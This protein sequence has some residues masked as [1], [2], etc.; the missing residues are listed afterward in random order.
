MKRILRG[1]RPLDYAI[2]AALTLLGILLM[3]HAGSLDLK[4]SRGRATVLAHLPVLN[5]V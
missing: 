1:V 4:V 5:G 2:A 3:A